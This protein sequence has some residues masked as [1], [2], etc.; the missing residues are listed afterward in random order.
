MLLHYHPLSPYSRKVSTALALRGDRVELKQIELGKGALQEPAFLA[1]SPFG[2]LPILETDAGPLIETTSIIE[3]LEEQGPRVLLPP[4]QE[5]IARHFDRIGDLYL[6]DPM[7]ALWW[8]PESDQGRGAERTAKQAWAL[9]ERQLD[10]RPFVA[11]SAFSL[12]D[13]SAAIAT[14][15]FERLG[16]K[17]PSHIRAWTARCFEVPAM[18][19]S[20][21][22]AVPWVRRVLGVRAHEPGR[23]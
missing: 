18:A 6:M 5:R 21:E 22:A 13:L 7:A 4:G 17:A 2:R 11:G 10:G 20:L 15:Y 1:V 16:V 23:V 19:S 3:W 8:R 14:D 9:L 12:G